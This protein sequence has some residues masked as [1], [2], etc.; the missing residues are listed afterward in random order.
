MLLRLWK[1]VRNVKNREFL[2]WLGGGAVVVVTGTFTLFTYLHDDKKPTASSTTVIAPA[3]TG[4]TSGHD[5]VVNAPVNIGVNEKR[6]GEQITD[7]QKPL[8]A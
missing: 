6:V 1:F 5:T 2:S 3:P 8:V 7:A 4:I